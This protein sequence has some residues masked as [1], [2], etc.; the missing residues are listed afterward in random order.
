MNFAD[1]TFAKSLRLKAVS[2][3]GKSVAPMGG[4][5]CKDWTYAN[6]TSPRFV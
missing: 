4:I 1:E 3:I 5:A 2:P 6:G